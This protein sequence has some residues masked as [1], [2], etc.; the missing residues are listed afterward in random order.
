MRG[1]DQLPFRLYPVEPTEQKGADAAGGLNLP[2]NWLDDRLAHFVQSL[3]RFG[4]QLLFHL[5]HGGGRLPRKFM[6]RN[7]LSRVRLAVLLLPCG[8]IE[9]DA[10]DPFVLY[11]GVAEISGVGAGGHRFAAQVLLH[12]PHMGASCC[13]SL[14][15]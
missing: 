4:F 11:L 2:E 5:L 6:G 14:V 12:A 8:Y 3:A 13:L 7:R 10:F 9:V 15:S 1:T